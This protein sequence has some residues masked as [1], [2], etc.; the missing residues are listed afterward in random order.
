MHGGD[1]YTD[2][3]QWD[4]SVNL[5]PLGCPEEVKQ[6]LQASL[7]H[8]DRYPDLSQR[9]F[10]RKVAESEGVRE[11]QV[12]G[13]SGASELLTAILRA[14]TPK[15]VLLPRPGFS[16]Y[17]HGV[18]ML[19]DCE[20]AYYDL[21]E[22][23]GFLLTEEIL[24]T[25]TADTDLVIVTNPNNP[26]GRLIPPDL[27][28]RIADRCREQDCALVAD[29]CFLK[30]AGGESLARLTEEYEKLYVLN[31][32]TKLFSLPG[33][34]IGY[35]ITSPNN[36]PDLRRQL[37]EWNMSVMAQTA[38]SACGEYLMKTAFLQETARLVRREREYLKEGLRNLGL[39]V[40]ESDASF[41]LLKSRRELYE[42]LKRKK[43]LIRS[44]DDYEGLPSGVYRVAVKSRE[45][46]ERLLQAIEEIIKDEHGN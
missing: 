20:I 10:R 45:E 5:N 37:P 43:I 34:R 9:T 29:E 24:K 15:K 44:C 3:V 38:G 35:V 6:A 18:R 46:N 2:S 33:V 16:G 8:A 31:A 19:K 11:T 42:G 32:Y 17:L 21:K 1:I 26:T 12:L 4:F 7:E 13:G 14:L 22:D 39:R 27:L 36:I 41:L 40:Y 25:I 30:L 23:R 28:R